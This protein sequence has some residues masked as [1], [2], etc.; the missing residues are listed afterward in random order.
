MR[1]MFLSVPLFNY[2]YENRQVNAT[3]QIGLTV[4]N[5]LKDR[6]VVRQF[7]NCP[8]KTNTGEHL[9]SL[10]LQQFIIDFLATYYS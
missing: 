9:L 3:V 8:F 4:K 1:T 2:I 7:L 6:S 10:G 5:L